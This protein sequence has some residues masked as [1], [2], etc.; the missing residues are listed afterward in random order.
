MCI[1]MKPFNPEGEDEWSLQEK[2]YMFEVS[3]LNKLLDPNFKV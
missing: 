3:K 2:L 1:A